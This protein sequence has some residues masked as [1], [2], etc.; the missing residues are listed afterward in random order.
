MHLIVC[1][2]V[3]GLLK[4]CEGDRGVG[5]VGEGR[6]RNKHDDEGDGRCSSCR[7]SVTSRQLAL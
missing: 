7:R 6:N 1:V 2:P 5:R 4:G 3:A